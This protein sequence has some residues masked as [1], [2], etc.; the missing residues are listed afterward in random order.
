MSLILNFTHPAL[1]LKCGVSTKACFLLYVVFVIFKYSQLKNGNKF[2]KSTS[3]VDSKNYKL[4]I[5]NFL[6][7]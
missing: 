3:M 6:K 7:Q 4:F 1:I 2:S 5:I